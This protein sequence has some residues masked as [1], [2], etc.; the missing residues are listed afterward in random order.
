[1]ICI[2]DQGRTLCAR[3]PETGVITLRHYREQTEHVESLRAVDPLCGPCE[4]MAFAR[5]LGKSEEPS[6]RG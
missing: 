1:M 6:P 4:A 2:Y 5:E 3:V